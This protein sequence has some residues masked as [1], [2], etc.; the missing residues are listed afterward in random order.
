M[1]STEIKIG[2]PKNKYEIMK[3]AFSSEKI[4]EEDIKLIT[5]DMEHDELKSTKIQLITFGQN[6]HLGA[7]HREDSDYVDE[8]DLLSEKSGLTGLTE[9]KTIVSSNLSKDPAYNSGSRYNNKL[10]AKIDGMQKYYLKKIFRDLNI[11]MDLPAIKYDF[12]IMDRMNADQDDANMFIIALSCLVRNKCH[13]LKNIKLDNFSSTEW[14][15]FYKAFE[16]G[17]FSK[18]AE[19][20]IRDCDGFDINK[21][22]EAIDKSDETLV[23]KTIIRFPNLEKKN[24]KTE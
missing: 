1:E 7:D 23:Q 21:L 15:H 24:I 9:H 20:I 14:T 5:K 22:K 11:E 12:E 3:I 10:S 17:I 8:S 6:Q 19:I 18:L 4:E 13:E 2:L 16:N